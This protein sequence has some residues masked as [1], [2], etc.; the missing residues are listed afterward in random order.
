MGFQLRAHRLP[1]EIL[2]RDWRVLTQTID[3]PVLTLRV[4]SVRIDWPPLAP[5]SR[6]PPATFD[7]N[8]PVQ[9]QDHCRVG[10]LVERET[11]GRTRSD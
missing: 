7:D 8:R 10:S 9:V 2:K 6:L 11:K 5:R 4:F 1:L 3:E